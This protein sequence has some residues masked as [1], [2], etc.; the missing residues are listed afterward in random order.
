MIVKSLNSVV[1]YQYHMY[2]MYCIVLMYLYLLKVL[3]VCVREHAG[4]GA[5]VGVTRDV[6][7]VRRASIPFKQL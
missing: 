5:H 6:G 1:R 7:C 2:L 4:T 3:N